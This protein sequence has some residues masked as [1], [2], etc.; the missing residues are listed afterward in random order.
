MKPIAIIAEQYPNIALFAVALFLLLPLFKLF[1]SLRIENRKVGLKQLELG[2]SIFK[3]NFDRASKKQRF[4]T[5]QLFES[6]Y[7]CSFSYEEISVL[8]RATN[9]TQAIEYFKK[10]KAF[11]KLSNSKKSFVINKD[12]KCFTVFNRK[13]YYGVVIAEFSAYFVTA[14]LSFIAYSLLWFIY[15]QNAWEAKAFYVSN[16]VWGVLLAVFGSLFLMIAFLILTR[17]GNVKFTDKLLAEYGD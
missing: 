13:I 8:M 15:S 5:E 14:M 10:C 12:Y 17:T 3:S 4:L 2:Q 6:M 1:S 11:V 9:P 16:I 7:K